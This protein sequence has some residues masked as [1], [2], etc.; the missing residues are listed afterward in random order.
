ML[1]ANDLELDTGLHEGVPAL[2]ARF[3][4]L[5]IVVNHIGG[6]PIDGQ[7]PDPARLELMRQ[8]AAHP[9][10][11]C[12]V[13]GL[14]DLRSQVKPAPTDVDFLRS[15][16]RRTMEYV[17]RGPADLRQR[18]AGIR[19]QRPRVRRHTSAW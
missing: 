11:Y 1:V 16:A 13:S 18:L 7:P 5:R 8:A 17:R 6:I 2:A 9:Q 14:M 3:P 10:V 19:P 4:E 15:G 12:K